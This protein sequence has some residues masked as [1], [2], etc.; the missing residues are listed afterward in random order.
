[1]QKG[2]QNKSEE[3]VNSQMKLTILIRI[4]LQKLLNLFKRKKK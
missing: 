4:N 3:E 1:M 2:Y